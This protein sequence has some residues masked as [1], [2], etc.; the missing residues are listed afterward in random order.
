MTDVTTNLKPKAECSCGCGAFGTL[1]KPWSDGTACVARVCRCRRCMG[2]R[3]R[4]RGQESQR[5]VAN[6]LGIPV[7]MGGGNEETFQSAARWE[8]KEG[9][10]VRPAVTAFRRMRDQSEQHRPI[11]DHRP[12]AGVATHDGLS[13]VVV[14]L[15]DV[16]EF[17]AAVLGLDR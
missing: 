8:M 10:Q 11:G 6:K 17:A 2:K 13:V 15:D 12:F 5:K 1:R 14:A 4:R 16:H 7:G 9:A 3:N